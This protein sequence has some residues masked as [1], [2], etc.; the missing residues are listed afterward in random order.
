MYFSYF[1]YSHK[2][3]VS[4]T[5]FFGTKIFFYPPGP[6]FRFRRQ[7]YYNLYLGS[8]P[9]LMYSP[10]TAAVYY[11]CF[12]FDDYLCQPHYFLLILKR[13]DIKHRC[14]FPQG[15]CYIRLIWPSILFGNIGDIVNR[16][17]I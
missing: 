4:T 10:Y 12:L 7:T 9:R 15:H 6:V 16:D 3:R 8:F 2:L 13:Y 1:T 11:L 17:F 5:I 14:P